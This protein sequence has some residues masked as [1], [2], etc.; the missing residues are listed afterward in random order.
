MLDLKFKSLRDSGVPGIACINSADKQVRNYKELDVKLQQN[1]SQEKCKQTS[2]SSQ[3]F[4]PFKDSCL[5]LLVEL[6][7]YLSILFMNIVIMMKLSQSNQFRKSFYQSGANISDE[8]ELEE[9]S[10]DQP[11]NT[12]NVTIENSRRFS[13]RF[14]FPCCTNVNQQHDNVRR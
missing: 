4:C 2:A 13:S 8:I 3:K 10:P 7:P 11:E 12:V 5:I 9:I 6:I 14:C 1:V